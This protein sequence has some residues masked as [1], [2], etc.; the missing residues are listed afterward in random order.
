[1]SNGCNPMT[2]LD[3][4]DVVCDNSGNRIQVFADL[5]HGPKTFVLLASAQPRGVT[6][7]AMSREEA[8]LCC[9][10]VMG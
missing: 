6:A 4:A 10:D 8:F 2:T 7:N 1:M 3:A 9:K 5:S